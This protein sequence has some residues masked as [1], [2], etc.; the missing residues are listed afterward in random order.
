MIAKRKNTISNSTSRRI[1][2]TILNGFRSYFADYLNL[3]LGA[4]ARFEKAD[5]LGGQR[6]HVERLALYKTKV[7]QVSALLPTITNK[8]ITDL[9]LWRQAKMAYTQLVYN[10]PNFEIAETFFNSVFG[11]INDHDKID[12][13]LIYV[14]SSQIKSPLKAEYSI[15]IRYEQLS[16]TQELFQCLLEEAEFSL[17]FEDL[18]RDVGNINSEFEQAV[19]P[20]LNNPITEL[21]FD[22]LEAVFYRGKA[23]YLIGRIVDGAQVL[24]CVLPIMNNE[25]GAIFVDTAIFNREEMSIIFSFAL[26]HFMVDAPLPYQYLNFIKQLLPHKSDYEIYSSLGFPIHAKTEFYRE[27]VKHL[28][29]SQEKFIIAPG[30]KGM[31]MSV[32][33]LPSY[34]VVFKLIKDRFDPPKEVT[35]DIVKEKYQMVSRHDRAGRLAD[36]QKFV[37]LT[38]PL[39]RFSDELL[40]ELKKVAPSQIEISKESNRILIRLLYTERKM[41]PLNIYLQEADDEQTKNAMEEYGNAI[42]QLAAA[43]IF[44]GDML[45]KNFGVTRHGRVVFY[46]YDEICLLTECNFRKIP[47]A[48]TEEQEMSATPWYSIGP[49]DVFPE[50]FSLFFSGNPKARKAFE[51][52]HSDLYKV[53]FWQRIQKRIRNG[54]V[55][56]VFP[57]RKNRRFVR[58]R[59][60]RKD[61]EKNAL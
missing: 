7:K 17:P 37:N 59:A 51:K 14:L 12:D 35:H 2:K 56:D 20:L 46:D 32:F 10:F 22:L 24:P 30:I 49:N 18:Q 48:Q 57:Y 5:W 25:K 26:S 43:N 1:A 9:E 50:E 4:K 34:D 16:S 40:E 36:T 61:A 42:K 45:L 38:L 52:M 53:E 21:K 23:A 41:I 54:T 33:T 28:R 39:D 29:R 44:P 58:R 19:T 27:L 8:D 11:D 6:A 3:T 60:M 13:D 47:E 31:V 15:F 55:I